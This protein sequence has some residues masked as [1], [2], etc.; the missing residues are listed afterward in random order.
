MNN[1]WI[2]LDQ[3]E[4]WKSGEMDAAAKSE[5]ERAIQTNSELAEELKLY[6]QLVEHIG[7]YGDLRTRKILER[8][9]RRLTSEGFFEPSKVEIMKPKKGILMQHWRTIAFAASFMLIMVVSFLIIQRPSHQNMEALVLNAKEIHKNIVEKKL[10][11]TIDQL[12]SYALSNADKGKDESLADALKLY[13]EYEYNQAKVA[14]L[15][16]LHEYPDDQ[17]AQMYLGLSYFQN[18]EYGRAAKYL[19][20]LTRDY[21]FEFKSIAK[22]YSAMC[23]RVFGSTTDI[24]TA[25]NLFKELADDPSNEFTDYAKAQLDLFD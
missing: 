13:Q 15:Q 4:A 7:T 8:V 10:D 24:I 23:Y 17:L 11:Y 3:I 9:E 20:P 6:D 12:K 22:W 18:A 25:K 14:L 2:N 19:T 16:Y 21:K 5:F 1:T